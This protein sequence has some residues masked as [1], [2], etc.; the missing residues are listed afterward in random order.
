MVLG[1]N[2]FKNSKNAIVLF[3][4]MV[5]VGLN[6]NVNVQHLEKTSSINWFLC[7]TSEIQV[8]MKE[9]NTFQKHERR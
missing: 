1:K 5:D 4:R 6:D 7:D 9:D 8:Y 3:K 2:Q